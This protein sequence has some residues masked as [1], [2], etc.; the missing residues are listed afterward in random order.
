MDKRIEVIKDGYVDILT[1]IERCAN[2]NECAP[3]DGCPAYEECLAL[4]QIIVKKCK[5]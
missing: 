5:R 2:E 1:G 4:W 3:G